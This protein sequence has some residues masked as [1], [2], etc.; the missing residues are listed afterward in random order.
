MTMVGW[1]RRLYVTRQESF[2]REPLDF[3]VPTKVPEACATFPLGF[4]GTTRAAVIFDDSFRVVALRPSATGVV[5]S[6][7]ATTSINSLLLLGLPIIGPL[8]FDADSFG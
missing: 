2:Q 1:A 3:S 7:K 4:F 5:T 8:S 6:A